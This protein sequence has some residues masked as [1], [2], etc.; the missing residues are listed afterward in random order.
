[1]R[2]DLRLLRYTDGKWVKLEAGKTLS[3]GVVF[4]A[5]YTHASHLKCMGQSL[6]LLLRNYQSG[7]MEK[8]INFY[9]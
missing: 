9:S 2:G 6:Q 5:G 7:E 8:I 1:M 4:S 3:D